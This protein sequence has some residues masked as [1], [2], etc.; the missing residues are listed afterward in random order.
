MVEELLAAG[1][2]RFENIEGSVD[3]IR[4]DL[5]TSTYKDLPVQEL[6]SITDFATFI[7][8]RSMLDVPPE[9]TCVAII[10][11]KSN[12]SEILQRFKRGPNGGDAT[13]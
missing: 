13:E 2:A 3:F 12:L 11:K 5:R 1:W 4:G 7:S 10:T 6:G 9:V 8:D